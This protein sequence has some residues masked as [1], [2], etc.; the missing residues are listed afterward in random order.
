[1]VQSVRQRLDGQQR[2]QVRFC[3]WF[4]VWTSVLSAR[5]HVLLARFR[6]IAESYHSSAD[7]PD[8]STRSPTHPA[9]TTRTCSSGLCLTSVRRCIVV[10][11]QNRLLAPHVIIR[12]SFSTAVLFSVSAAFQ[13]SSLWAGGIV[14]YQ[15]KIVFTTATAE[16]TRNPRSPIPNYRN[17]D[18]SAAPAGTR[19]ERVS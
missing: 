18:Q 8:N 12:A 17:V 13:L 15:W 10:A 14:L 1:M 5:V 16:V 3:V 11:P 9:H 2:P 6:S 7:S 4:S 19:L